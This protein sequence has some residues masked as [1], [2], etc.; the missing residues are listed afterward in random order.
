M[1]P[2]DNQ[3]TFGIVI[4]GHGSRDP[5]GIQEFE[6]LVELIKERAPQHIVSHGYLEFASPTIDQAVVAQ[7]DAGAQ[8]VVMVPGVLLA[9]SHA[10]NDMP[11]E[12]LAFAQTHPDIDFHFGAPLGM[13]PL[14]LQVIQEHIVAL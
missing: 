5:D 14:L 6:Q 3:N 2:A 7:L 13:H 12:L 9:A 4:A 10:K 8:Q 11:S 1:M